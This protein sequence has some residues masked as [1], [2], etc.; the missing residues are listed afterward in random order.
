MA[1]RAFREI[2]DDAGRKRAV[3]QAIESVA[4]QLGNT[5]AVCRA[6]YVHPDVVEA[7]LD[8]TLVEALAERAHG[9]G[10]GAHALRAEEAAVLGL[11]Q[12]RLA[13]E[14]RRRRRAA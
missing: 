13:R 12:A 10:R 4:G 8:G 3:V 14:V 6:C 9:A 2:D 11:L 7:Y 5:P 1:L